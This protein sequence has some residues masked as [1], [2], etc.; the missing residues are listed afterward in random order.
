LG[1]RVHRGQEGRI[2]SGRTAGD[3]VFGYHTEFVDPNALHQ[4][5]RG[6]RPEKNVFVDE[7]QAGL[8]R[9]VFEQ[10]ADGLSAAKIANELTC[11]EAPC[12]TRTSKTSWTPE[13]IRRMVANEKYIGRWRWGTTTTI[14]D[15]TG[16][17]KQVPV[18]AAKHVVVDRPDLRIVDEELWKKVQS[19]REHARRVYGAKDGQQPRGPRIHHTAV[20]PTSLL[21]GLLVCGVCG[22]R[23]HYMRSGPREYYGCPQHAKCA[24]Q[25]TN[26]TR[27]PRQRAEERILEHITAILRSVPGWLEVVIDA[28]R[29]IVLDD[30]SRAPEDIRHAELQLAKLDGQIENLIDCMAGPAKGSDAVANRLRALEAEAREV[31]E[32]LD[33]RRKSV[34]K[35]P[36][37]PGDDWFAGKWTGL[38]TIFQER[39]VRA[40][41]LIRRLVDCIES[42]PAIP[43]G[44]RR[45]FAELR[46][47]YHGSQVIVDLLKTLGLPTSPT[48]TAFVDGDAGRSA[49]VVIELARDERSRAS[50]PPDLSAEFSGSDAA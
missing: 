13:R 42:F 11:Q 36:M 7:T 28:T 25:F 45:G 16:K 49:E 3:I 47:R 14:R 21:G 15:S 4:R 18:D 12:G 41:Q 8:V 40:F 38:A 30:A 10:F 5:H 48:T 20:Y 19:R 35:V 31:R 9:F 43:K 34:A 17:K 24:S 2:R 37:L 33:E 6:P 39:G 44:K 29:K 50:K 46:Y 22:T 23:M 27:V 32:R 26:A 1:H